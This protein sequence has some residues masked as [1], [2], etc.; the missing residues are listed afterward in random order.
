[1]KRIKLLVSLAAVTTATGAIAPLALTS[2]GDNEPQ[3]FTEIG[4]ETITH[5]KAAVTTPHTSNLPGDNG[6]RPSEWPAQKG[7]LRDIK[8]Y[9]KGLVNKEL[10]VGAWQEQPDKWNGDNL[11]YEGNSYFTMP[12]TEG[13]ENKP[14][15]ILQGQMDMVWSVVDGYTKSKFDKGAI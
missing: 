14:G 11:E 9:Y 1:M 4:D 13:W 10:G 3:K 7:N 12:A 2:C 8:D 6:Q 5:F 15:I